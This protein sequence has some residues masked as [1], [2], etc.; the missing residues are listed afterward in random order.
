[1]QRQSAEQWEWPVARAWGQRVIVGEGFSAADTKGHTGRGRLLTSRLVGSGVVWEEK[2]DMEWGL[3][4]GLGALIMWIYLFIHQLFVFCSF[5]NYLLYMSNVSSTVLCTGGRTRKF[6]V[7]G[8][9]DSLTHHLYALLVS[10]LSPR[11]RN[12]CLQ[13]F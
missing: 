8:L 2:S 7:P 11:N 12:P 10:S 1:M 3:L 6:T 5:I 9:K 4:E 13:H